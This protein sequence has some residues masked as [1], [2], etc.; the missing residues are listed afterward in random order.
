MAGSIIL[1][2]DHVLGINTH[3][4]DYMVERIRIAYPVEFDALEEQVFAPMDEGG[5]MFISLRKQGK[6]GVAAFH[7]ALIRAI[8]RD[9]NEGTFPFRELLWEQLLAL[10]RTD[11]RFEENE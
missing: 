1:D 8:E 7:S 11:P 2:R 6:E 5:M 3:D 9:I 4:F 10:V